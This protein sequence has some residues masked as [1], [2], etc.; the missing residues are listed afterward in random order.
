MARRAGGELGKT[1]TFPILL[2]VSRPCSA[3]SDRKKKPAHARASPSSRRDPS[4]PKAKD[5]L[6]ALGA[7]RARGNTHCYHRRSVCA[8][9]TS[10]PTLDSC[11]FV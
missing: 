8:N 9:P 10:L 7:M 5:R 6:P 1:D 4:P 11:R 3:G 2:K